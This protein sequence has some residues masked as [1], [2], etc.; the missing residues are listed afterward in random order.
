M[1]KKNNQTKY[2]LI[3]YQTS[4]KCNYNQN[5]VMRKLFTL[6]KFFFDEF[7][8]YYFFIITKITIIN[9]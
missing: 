2:N 1:R 5:K 7:F 6:K 9:S 3:E 8:I 4:A